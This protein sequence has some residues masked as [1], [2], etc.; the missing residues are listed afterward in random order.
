MD[1]QDQN[2]TT[3]TAL[4]IWGSE[5]LPFRNTGYNKPPIIPFIEVKFN[6]EGKIEVQDV[7]SWE[8]EY[9][10]DVGSPSMADKH[11]QHEKEGAAG[12]VFFVITSESITWHTPIKLGE[13]HRRI[14]A[15]SP[16]FALYRNLDWVQLLNTGRIAGN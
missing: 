3:L 14:R 11:A 9:V 10:P 6:A 15:N 4:A 16:E 13:D 1:W 7:L 12:T 8:A 2:R 5:I